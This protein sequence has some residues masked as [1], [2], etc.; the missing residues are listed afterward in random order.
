MDERGIK[1]G[2]ADGTLV[3]NP[4]GSVRPTSLREQLGLSV[5]R[6]LDQGRGITSQDIIRRENLRKMAD[7]Y[8]KNCGCE[9]CRNPRQ[10][11]GLYQCFAPDGHGGCRNVKICKNKEVI[12]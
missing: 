9:G 10:Q 11:E 1:Q 6:R 3:R 7:R 8:F 12:A 5:V 2:L 4:D